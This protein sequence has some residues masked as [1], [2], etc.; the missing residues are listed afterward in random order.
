MGGSIV[1]PDL[2]RLDP[3][4]HNFVANPSSVQWVHRVLGTLLALAMVW[5]FV[6]VR[7]HVGDA[8]SRR[9]ATSF[10]ALTG[11]QYALVVALL[12]L[13]VPVSLGVI[14]QA[15]AMALFGVWLC[16]LHRVVS[17]QVETG[18]GA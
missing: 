11:V 16:W 5:L 4:L 7:R 8:V 15:T 18:V 2:L 14:H 9:Y 10:L 6:R 1:P 12:L 13:L 3:A 17:A